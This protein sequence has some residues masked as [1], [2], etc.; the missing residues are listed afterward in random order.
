MLMIVPLSEALPPAAINWIIAGGLCLYG[1]RGLLR[2]QTLALHT[3]DMASVCDCGSG[4]SLCRHLWLCDL[5][6]PELMTDTLSRRVISNQ[7]GPHER[8]EE[9]VRKHLK[10]A[11]SET[12]RWSFETRL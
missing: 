4:L 2:S 7:S 10:H 1:W 8:L 9:T 12:D 3:C 11:Q 5:V 6:Q